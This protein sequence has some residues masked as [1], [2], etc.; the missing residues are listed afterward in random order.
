[1]HAVHASLQA[2]EIDYSVAK[3]LD[4]NTRM[5]SLEKVVS[6]FMNTFVA[7]LRGEEVLL[8]ELRGM[9]EI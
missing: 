5:V 7:G 8:L 3:E 2:A 9:L 1:M 4:N 6:Y